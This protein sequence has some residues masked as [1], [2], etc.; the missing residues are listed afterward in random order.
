[1]SF[2]ILNEGGYATTTKILKIFS[3]YYKIRAF[4]SFLFAQYGH[5]FASSFI[6]EK[7]TKNNNN[8]NP[9]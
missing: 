6:K 2:Y 9:L 4:H 5:D 7:N 8:Q 1:M 3:N